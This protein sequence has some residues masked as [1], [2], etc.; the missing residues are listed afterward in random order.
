[1]RADAQQQVVL[2]HR[3]GPAVV[4]A[5]PG[6]GKTATIIARTGSMLIEGV[7]PEQI[8]LLTF[9]RK[10]CTE[11]RQRLAKWCE[12]K[13]VPTD[14][15]TRTVIETFHS[16]GL[17]FLRNCYAQAGFENPVNM[18][19][20]Q[21]AFKL[22]KEVFPPFEPTFPDLD[23][24]AVKAMLHDMHQQGIGHGKPSREEWAWLVDLAQGDQGMAH[25]LLALDAEYNRLK[26]QQC[27][28]DY[29]D[30]LLLPVKVLREFPEV[31][32]A[33][34]SRFADV[35]VD[36][37]QDTN[38][39][40]FRMVQVI[41]PH[42][43]VVM[44]GDDD[45]LI[46]E[47]RGARMSNLHDFIRDSGA[48]VLKLENN[49]RSASSIVN[50]TAQQIVRNKQRLD[51]TPNPTR[52]DV[53]QLSAQSSPNSYDLAKRMIQSFARQIE[54]SGS[55]SIAVLYR[56]NRLSRVLE[57]A[58]ID[59]GIPY[60]IVGGVKL[61]DRVEIKQALAIAR[62]V[63]NLFDYTAWLRVSDLIKGLGETGLRHMHAA[64]LSGGLDAFEEAIP[65]RA[66]ADVQQLI[67][68]IVKL[69]DTGPREWLPE[70]LGSFRLL[71]RMG[72][73]DPADADKRT[74]ALMQLN[75]W[76]VRR[77]DQAEQNRGGTLDPVEAW[78]LVQEFLVSEDDA[79]T[80][81]KGITLS[82]IHRAK[83]LEWQH[84][85]VLG[86]SDP[87]LPSARKKDDPE[88]GEEGAANIEEERRLCYVAVTR[89]KETCTLWHAD[90][91]NFGYETLEAKPS[92][93]IE[94]LGLPP[95]TPPSSTPDSKRRMPAF[96]R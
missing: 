93:F 81:D 7:H 91:Y 53:G 50:A 43:R 71:E 26:R 1:M 92:R 61:T 20:E 76:L 17:K 12:I 75:E 37:A 32:A 67:E 95:L 94:E 55:E 2:A 9:S 62:L 60:R 11:M 41:A 70:L 68:V 40:Q 54:Q 19:D 39:A 31:A 42:N 78:Q 4:T 6:S 13:G 3:N 8:L 89:A 72:V 51:K 28:V 52:Q 27:V 29:D 47:W 56:T 64:M 74:A 38:L 83:G 88:D 69:H 96:M 57:P 58:L 82:S 36:E 33:M 87:I 86:M 23:L 49:Y 77:I 25:S 84:V 59:A 16:F 65:K 10:A 44:V 46:Y 85:H 79:E 63:S 24:K 35:T 80:N 66:K 34:E 48:T 5:G 22:L 30:L 90:S 18:L 14:L 15:A 73:K 45:Q 21:D